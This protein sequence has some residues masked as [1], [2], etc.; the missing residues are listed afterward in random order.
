MMRVMVSIF[1]VVAFEYE[2][3]RRK[4]CPQTRD[5]LARTVLFGFDK[6]PDRVRLIVLAL[7]SQSFEWTQS[8]SANA[9]LVSKSASGVVP[10]LGRPNLAQY[11]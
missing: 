4:Y 6:P 1:M 11:A 8:Q 7:V 2:R 5:H 3:E 10:K 9:M